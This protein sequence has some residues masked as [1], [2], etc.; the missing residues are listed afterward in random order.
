MSKFP[1]AIACLV[2]LLAGSAFGQ[3]NSKLVVRQG[4]EGRLYMPGPF[5]RIELAGTTH[6]RLLQ[7]EQDQ[8]FIVGDA[9]LQDSVAVT[10]S[11][12]RLDIRGIETWKFW[13]TKR[14][15][16]EVS[17]RRLRELVLSGAGELHAPDG[18]TAGPLSIRI[19][20]A[21]SVRFDDLTAERLDF[22]IS[23]SGVGVLRGRVE[24]LDLKISGKGKLQAEDLLAEAANI[25]ISGV[26]NADLW[27]SEKLN[28]NVSGVGHI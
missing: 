14:L 1:V 13:G 27:V 9:Q 23:G 19:S 24:L 11:Q 18:I 6:V 8:V 7:G 12:G 2:W 5:D 16:V 15:E 28:L 26:G 4:V 21:G 25:K 20:G 22:N 10:V 17:L 3:S